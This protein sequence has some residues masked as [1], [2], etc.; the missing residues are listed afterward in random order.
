MSQMQMR[1]NER[2]LR[3]TGSRVRATAFS[4]LTEAQLNTAPTFWGAAFREG[5]GVIS[6][7]VPPIAPGTQ[8]SFD[9]PPYDPVLKA[10]SY[11]LPGPGGHQLGDAVLLQGE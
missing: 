10:H 2:N 9:L 4:L 11:A 1:C 6:A 7:A 5:R 3:A 8:D